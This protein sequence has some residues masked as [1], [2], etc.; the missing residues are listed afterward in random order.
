[1]EKSTVLL[2]ITQILAEKMTQIQSEIQSLENEM[3]AESKSSAGDKYETSREMMNQSLNR[4]SQQLNQHQIQQHQLKDLQQSKPKLTVDLGSLVK[5]DKGLFLFG[6]SIGNITIE[7]C[8]IFVLSLNSPIGKQFYG[9]K[10]G[11]KV[12]MNQREYNIQSIA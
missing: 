1:M 7:N 10:A 4:L 6:L 5:T 2:T 8:N 11:E 3:G 9:K 12:V